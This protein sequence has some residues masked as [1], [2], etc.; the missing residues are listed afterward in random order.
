MW[1]FGHHKSMLKRLIFT[2]VVLA[3]SATSI[4][5]EGVFKG[6]AGIEDDATLPGFLVGGMFSVKLP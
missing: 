6:G 1:G 3:T 5:L 4:K 2:V